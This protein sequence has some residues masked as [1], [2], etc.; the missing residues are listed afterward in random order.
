VGDAQFQQKCLG[1]MDEVSRR[2]GRTVLFCPL[3]H[4]EEVKARILFETR[5]P[6]DVGIN[7]LPLGPETYS[8]HIC[9]CSR[10]SGSFD[11][12]PEA[13]RFEV[14]PGSTTPNFF[15]SK[16]WQMVH[17]KGRWEWNLSNSEPL[18]RS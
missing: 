9:C 17:V 8:L 5:A 18:I 4:G 12:V 3:R 16:R 1:R 10:D 6:V 15:R 2:E 13:L 7:T 11:Y 14:L